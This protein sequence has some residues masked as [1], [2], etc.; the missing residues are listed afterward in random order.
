MP[1]QRQ[2]LFGMLPMAYRYSMLDV[3][4]DI[5][6]VEG[7][8]LPIGESL[9]CG[10]PAIC[11][12]DYGAKDEVYADGV[13]WTTPKTHDWWHT[14]TRLWLADLDEIVKA[15]EDFKRSKSLRQYWAET[16]R[17]WALQYKW[18]DVRTLFVSLVKEGAWKNQ[19]R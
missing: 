12:H 9:M 18:D 4:L 2:A 10:T 7:F 16:G 3:Y 17:K 5:S 1:E 19:G 6:S 13:Y 11:T 14:G 15:V 8:G